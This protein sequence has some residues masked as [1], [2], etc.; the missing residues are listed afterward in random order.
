MSDRDSS[1][2]CFE[3]HLVDILLR[4]NPRK[5]KVSI[6]FPTEVSSRLRTTHSCSQTSLKSSDPLVRPS[7]LCDVEYARVYLLRRLS[8]LSLKLE[9][10]LADFGDVLEKEMGS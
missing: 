5:T 9:P 6:F 1:F 3:A 8:Q 4:S 2:L 10:S 7:L